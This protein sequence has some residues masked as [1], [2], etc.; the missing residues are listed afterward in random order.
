MRLEIWLVVEV[1]YGRFSVIRL[2]LSQLCLI[3]CL[4]LLRLFEKHFHLISLHC[5]RQQKGTLALTLFHFGCLIINRILFFPPYRLCFTRKIFPYVRKFGPWD[6]FFYLLTHTSFQALA[7]LYSRLYLRNFPRRLEER[8]FIYRLFAITREMWSFILA[9]IL[10]SF[11]RTFCLLFVRAR[12]LATKTLRL[13][14]RSARWI[15]PDI[16]INIC[17]E[18][19]LSSNTQMLWIVPKH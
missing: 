3:N 11:L 17:W 10:E 5:L 12:T 14:K 2:T 15:T 4:T 19:F 18:I 7:A 8:Q 13:Q 9:L 6:N 1:V 16:V